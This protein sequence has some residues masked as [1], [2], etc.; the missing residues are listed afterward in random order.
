MMFLP[1]GRVLIMDNELFKRT[2]DQSIVLDLLDSDGSGASSPNAI[3]DVIQQHQIQVSHRQG[4]AMLPI[5]QQPAFPQDSMLAEEEK[6]SVGGAGGAAS[7]FYKDSNRKQSQ[8][9]QKKR[10]PGD[11]Q[12]NMSQQIDSMM[13]N[14]QSLSAAGAQSVQASLTD[15]DQTM[16]G[17]MATASAQ[18]AATADPA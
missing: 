10:Q 13:I 17:N 15:I 14:N 5:A 16:V 18:A 12:V 9:N 11:D 7:R 1:D 4:G 2:I 3:L 6:Q 8:A